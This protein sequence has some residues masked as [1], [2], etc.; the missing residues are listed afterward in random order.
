MSGRDEKPFEG[1]TFLLIRDH[2]QDDGTEPL[3]AALPAWLS[4]D[5]TVVRPDGSRGGEAVAGVLNSVEIVVHNRGGVD[6]IG[7][8][9]DAFFA[10]PAIG[11]TP[12]TAALI[13]GGAI[14][15]PG[16]GMASLSLPW[17]PPPSYAGHGCILARASLV[18]PPDTYADPT[19]FDTRGDRHIAQRNIEVVAMRAGQGGAFGFRLVNPA[20]EA[21]RLR[22]QFREIFEDAEWHALHRA[23]GDRRVVPAAKALE[24]VGLSL[25]ERWKPQDDLSVPIKPEVPP[26]FAAD[27]MARELDARLEAGEVRNAAL[28]FVGARDAAPGAAH[29][30]EV[31][32]IDA[33]GRVMGGLTILLRG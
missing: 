12:L 27:R 22:V 11:M 31:R 9:V 23:L 4:P 2:P 24:R 25:G 14:D 7:T 6:A 26:V 30:I 18:I 19:N 13:G 3:A 28:H 15:V 10:A 16:Y 1:R 17:L 29:A 21:Q 20:P 32:Q 5:I 33:R 8:W